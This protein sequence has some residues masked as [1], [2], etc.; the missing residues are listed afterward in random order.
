MK[1][2]NYANRGQTLE[3]FI[4]YANQI[5]RNEGVAVVWKVPTH[6]IPIR[7]YTG[8]IVSCKVEEKSCVDYLGRVWNTPIAAEA[9]ES[10]GDSIRFD[11]VQD[12][13]ALF[14]DDYIR[15]ENGIGLVI[16]SFNLQ[17]F[18][19]IPWIFWR[20]ARDAWKDAQR[21]GKRKAE[22]KTIVYEGTT[23]TTPGKA[24]VKE[25]EL[26]PEWKV[27]TGGRYGLNYLQKYLA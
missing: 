21:L 27:E 18:Y 1:Q 14:L 13:Q 3:H 19:A 23:W 6:F 25:S 2:R 4:S 9:K 16:I 11:A 12:H 17:N 15:G 10:H 5:Y 8:R 7:D 26:L 20:A 22:Q 24:S